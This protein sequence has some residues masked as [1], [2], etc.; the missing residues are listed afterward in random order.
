V[1]EIPD[2]S[3]NVKIP[4]IWLDLFFFFFLLHHQFRILYRKR[5][6]SKK[7]IGPAEKSP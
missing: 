6:T 3:A 4:S 7:I 1:R 5:M 2:D